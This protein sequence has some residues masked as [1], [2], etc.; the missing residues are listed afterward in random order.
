MGG[1]G[2]CP[3][4]TFPPLLLLRRYSA[5]KEHLAELDKETMAALESLYN[6]SGA[7]SKPRGRREADRQHPEKSKFLRRFPLMKLDSLHAKPTVNVSAGYKRRI[8][9]GI[10]SG[11]SSIV[12]VRSPQ[13]VVGFQ[14]V[15]SPSR[16]AGVFPGVPFWGQN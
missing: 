2:F 7:G 16:R 8:S 14:L 10:I 11:S 1:G 12:N 4:P 13:D 6:F 9:A 5:I 3:P 15:S